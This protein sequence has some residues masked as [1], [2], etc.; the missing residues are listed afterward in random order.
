MIVHVGPRLDVY[1]VFVQWRKFE[2]HIRRG[3][4]GTTLDSRK[5]LASVKSG[6]R[7]SRSSLRFLW[8]LVAAR[9]ACVCMFVCRQ[10]KDKTVLC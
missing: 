10:G 3:R 1:F 6:C 9:C 8:R 2:G 4:V 5:N 7:F